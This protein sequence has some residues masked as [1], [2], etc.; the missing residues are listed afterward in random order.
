[1]NA[2]VVRDHSVDAIVPGFLCKPFFDWMMNQYRWQGAEASANGMAAIA[3]D[4]T[5][6]HGSP[7]WVPDFVQGWDGW[8]LAR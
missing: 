1:M 8:K 5:D 4:G 6:V 3:S 2:I 7:E